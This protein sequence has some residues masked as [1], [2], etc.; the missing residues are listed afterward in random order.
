L[1]DGET[2][3][4][5]TINRRDDLLVRSANILYRINGKAGSI[6]V[7]NY[8]ADNWDASG[9]NQLS[10][11]PTSGLRCI[12][13]LI[14]LQGAQTTI[15][16][17]WI[18]VEP[19]DCNNP[20]QTARLDWWKN[21]KGGAVA[22]L[23]NATDVTI[24]DAVVTDENGALIDL[25][26]YV[27]KLQE[28]QAEWWMF[29]RIGSVNVSVQTVKAKVT[30]QMTYKEFKD[31]ADAKPTKSGIF[32]HAAVLTLTN[33]QSGDYSAI[34]SI[35]SAGEYFAVGSGGIAEYLFNHMNEIQYDGNAIHVAADFADP[36]ASN[37]VDLG[38]TLN[39]SGGAAEWASMN[40]QIQS[41]SEDYFT[42]DV[43]VEIG[44]ASHLNSGQL[45]ALLNMW[46]GRRNW[47]M[48]MNRANLVQ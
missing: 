4:S 33:G 23:E 5:L 12:E 41:I 45:S 24:E 31:P 13:E 2:H 26:F 9:W 37:Y 30:A 8:V 19:L 29:K 46:R 42:K 36:T 15:E 48:V 6:P 16:K 10:P 7:I 20:D 11:P 27:N 18:S 32:T 47:F 21:V 22:V 28:G 35:D 38:N 39:L 34:T 25:N 40:A 14:D 17:G 1:F 44:V 43:T 3:K